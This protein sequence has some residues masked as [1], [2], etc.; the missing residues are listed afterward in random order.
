V[1]PADNK[2]YRNWAVARILIE[3]LQE[4]DPQYPQ[5]KLDIPRLVRRLRA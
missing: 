3:T 5:P 4:M 1:V 2:D